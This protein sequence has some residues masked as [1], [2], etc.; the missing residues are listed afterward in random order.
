[1]VAAPKRLRSP[2]RLGLIEALQ[3]GLNQGFCAALFLAIP[4][5]QLF[6]LLMG[7]EIKL[8]LF[9]YLLQHEE[10][11]LRFIPGLLKLT[12]QLGDLA[13]LLACCGG[14]SC[15]WIWIGD[16]WG[17]GITH[18]RYLKRRF[19]FEPVSV[20]PV[21]VLSPVR[22]RAPHVEIRH[23]SDLPDF[24]TFIES[25]YPQW[26]QQVQRALRLM[27]L[28]GILDP[29]SLQSVPAA[30][31]R[32]LGDN[33]RETFEVEGCLARHRA[34]LLVLKELIQAGDLPAR[35]ALEIYCPEAITPFAQRLRALFPLFMGSEYLPDRLDRLRQEIP[36]QDLCALT[37][38][39]AS[40]H[41]VVCNELFEHLY[42]LP[43]ALAE[44]ARVLRPGG[45]LVSTFP[46][47]YDRYETIVKARHRPGATPGVAAEAELLLEPEFHGNPVAP[48]QGSLVYQIPGWDLLDQAR[49]A[50]LSRPTIQWIAAP[51]YGVVGQEI[52]AVLVLVA[53]RD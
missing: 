1:M 28:Y 51:S 7:Q 6:L 9:L 8:Q 50:G 12:L 16:G 42:D 4:Q 29:I 31:L 32:K 27:A 45:V 25:S 33:Y 49:A 43:A 30:A 46:F 26:P 48:E 18:Q 3:Q 10:V 24:Q 5:Q 40:L 47:A 34:V 37:L 20:A 52:P 35:D 36:H 17:C 22:F 14:G 39:D 38:S 23:F 19:C 53:H 44:V 15:A 11:E 2:L 21:G 13:R 41:A